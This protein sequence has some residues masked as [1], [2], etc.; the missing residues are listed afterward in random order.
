MRHAP[1]RP[2]RTGV[3][4][5]ELAFILTFIFVPVLFGVWEVGRLIQIQQVVDN[6]VREGARAASTGEYSNAQVQ[7]VV[8]NYLTNSGVS[9]TNVAVTVADLT[10]PGDVSSPTVNSFGTAQQLDSLQVTVSVPFS[11]VY[12]IALN[13]FVAAGSTMNSSANTVSMVNVP[14]TIPTNIPAAPQ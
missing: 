8:L 2:C 11:N 1:D 3:A 13:Y 4:A 10:H 9:T 12:W 6:S 5:V 7:Q 14:L